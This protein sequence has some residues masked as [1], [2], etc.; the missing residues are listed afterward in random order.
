MNPVFQWVYGTPAQKTT[1]PPT[2]STGISGRIEQAFDAASDK[3]QVESFAQIAPAR[4][5]SMKMMREGGAQ[6]YNPTAAEFRQWVDACGEQRKEWDEFK[7]RLAGSLD[8]FDK[9]MVSIGQDV[10]K[11]E[12]IYDDTPIELHAE[13]IVDRLGRDGPMTFRQVFLGR[14]KRSEIVG[15]FLAMLELVRQKRIFAIQDSNFDEIRIHLN[16]KPPSQQSD[17]EEAQAGGGED[18]PMEPEES[19]VAGGY[20]G[21]YVSHAPESCDEPDED[22]DDCGREIEGI[23]S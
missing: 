5:V 22:E 23:G 19:P 6:F 12:V 17:Q 20:A 18:R 16:T 7:V 15:L 13:D 1:A 21:Q 14:T 10:R 3:T 2:A 4:E 9:L 8:A 11:H